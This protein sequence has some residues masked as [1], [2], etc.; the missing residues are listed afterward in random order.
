MTVSSLTHLKVRNGQLAR[1]KHIVAVTLIM[2]MPFLKR[3]E[4]RDRR[5]AKLKPTVIVTNIN[6]GKL[7]IIE[8]SKFENTYS[9]NNKCIGEGIEYFPS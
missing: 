1:L 5:V 9:C 4:V 6:D 7:Q 8:T 3:L 2:A